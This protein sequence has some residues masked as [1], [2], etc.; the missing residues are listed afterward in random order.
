M[1]RTNGRFFREL[2][3]IPA[4]AV[5]VAALLL[6]AG[7]AGIPLLM[8]HQERNPPPLPLQLFFGFFVG[9]F[10][11]LYALAV[12]YVNRDARRRGMS[13]A[14]W[15]LLVIFVPNAIGFILYFV[16]RSP[17]VTACPGCQ[18]EVRAGTR[19]C[20]RCG[21]L[22]RPGCAGCGHALGGDEAFCVNCGRAVAA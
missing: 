15:T 3:I 8:E 22:L 19:Y 18:A 7:L 13:A 16:T 10:L 17:V 21:R 1:S 6:L 5:V 14:L 12:G 20:P 11:G 2:S 9:S 4:A